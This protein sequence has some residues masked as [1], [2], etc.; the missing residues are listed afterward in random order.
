DDYPLL[1]HRR[2]RVEAIDFGAQASNLLPQIRVVRFGP[3][4]CTHERDG[5]EYGKTH[6][7]DEGTEKDDL[8]GAEL[9][10]AGGGGEISLG[11][12]PAWHG[13]D[14]RQAGCETNHGWTK[15]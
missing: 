5:A 10:V 4:A 2:E 8:V 9:S 7:P 13:S 15:Q 11:P 3:T 14:G 12:Q 1:I 6:G